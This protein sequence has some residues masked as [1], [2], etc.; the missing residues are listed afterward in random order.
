MQAGKVIF[1]IQQ[2]HAFKWRALFLRSFLLGGP[3]GGPRMREKA[4]L[5]P[6]ISPPII[7]PSPPPPFPSLSWEMQMLFLSKW[8]SKRFVFLRCSRLCSPPFTA[9]MMLALG[10]S[11]RIPLRD[12]LRRAQSLRTSR[13]E[14]HSARTRRHARERASGIISQGVIGAITSQ[15]RSAVKA[16]S[17][18]DIPPF[19]ADARVEKR[20][21]VLQMCHDV[22]SPFFFLCLCCSSTVLSYISTALD[23]GLFFPAR[24]SA[25]PQGYSSKR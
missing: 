19:F 8:P 1:Y 11:S 14:E 17:T 24:K 25:P 4:P 7:I 10:R 21:S 18:V 5:T 15:T 13:R 23:A 3:R 9:D 6:S 20:Y 22:S 12:A 16:S 2:L